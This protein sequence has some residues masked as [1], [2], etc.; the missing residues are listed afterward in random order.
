MVWAREKEEVE[1]Y[2][3]SGGTQREGVGPDL[4]QS[5]SIADLSAKRDLDAP[6][7]FRISTAY[8]VQVASHDERCRVS[9]EG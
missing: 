1:T 8:V 4:G 6:I 5:N 2:L 3:N 9:E 7:E